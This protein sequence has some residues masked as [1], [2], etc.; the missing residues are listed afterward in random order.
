M[1]KLLLLMLT[2]LGAVFGAAAALHYLFPAERRAHLCEGLGHMPGAMMERC[3]QSMPADSPPKVMM[4]GLRRIQEQNDEVIVL[5]RQQNDLLRQRA[6]N[7]Q[8]S[9]PGS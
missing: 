8:T 2:L 6:H 5:L 9:S 4:S 1:K 7:G 3:M